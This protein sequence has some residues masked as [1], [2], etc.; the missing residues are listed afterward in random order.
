MKLKLSAVISF[1]V[2]TQFFFCLMQN[3]IAAQSFNF[4]GLDIFKLKNCMHT[5]ENLHSLKLSLYESHPKSKLSKIRTH[6][7]VNETARNFRDI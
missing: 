2:S 3:S 5:R 6:G 4:V 7:Q 1:I